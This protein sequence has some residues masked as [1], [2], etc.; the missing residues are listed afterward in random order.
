MRAILSFLICVAAASAQ[1]VPP[2]GSGGGGS[3]DVTGAAAL[4]TVSRCVVVSAAGVIKEVAGCTIDASGNANMASLLT[5]VGSGKTGLQCYAGA[6]SGNVCLS[7]ADAGGTDIAYLMPVWDGST[8]LVG[9]TLT[10]SGA[11]T[12][13]TFE[14]APAGVSWPTACHQLTWVSKPCGIVALFPGSDLANSKTAI[15]I[16]DTACTL[17]A[18]RIVSDA[19]VTA[20]FDVARIALS[21]WTGTGT[22]TSIVGTGTKPVITAATQ[23]YGTS[24][25][26]ITTGGAG[27]SGWTSV[28]LVAGD[29]LEI[30]LSGVTAGSATK[31][32]LILT[33]TRLN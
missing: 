21:S 25:Q 2:G 7:V 15:T 17:T 14:T 22:G 13:P 31:L 28:T 32:M 30:T 33:G 8:S 3:G 18:A 16:S 24:G 1:Y 9:K 20:T 11:V 27:Y 6:A 4:T 23:A 19:T 5:G 29:A 26:T 12:C 10:D